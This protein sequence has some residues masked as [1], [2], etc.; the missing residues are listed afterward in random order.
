MPNVHTQQIFMKY[1]FQN[2]YDDVL[3]KN[4]PFIFYNFLQLFSTGDAHNR[5]MNQF[6]VWGGHSVSGGILRQ[7]Q[8]MLIFF[9]QEPT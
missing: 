1:F 2:I 5:N 8:L 3:L 4:L 7:H 9:N 6:S